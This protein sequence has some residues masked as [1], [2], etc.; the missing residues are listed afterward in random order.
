MTKETIIISIVVIL[1]SALVIYHVVFKPA[2][3]SGK[4]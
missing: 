4:V 1:I 3:N 2:I